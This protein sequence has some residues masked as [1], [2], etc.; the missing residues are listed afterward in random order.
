MKNYE[1][2]CFS[3]NLRF[4]IVG[5]LF[6]NFLS[7]HDFTSTFFTKPNFIDTNYALKK[8]DMM[9]NNILSKKLQCKLWLGNMIL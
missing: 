5:R 7:E 2:F 8:F 9:Y 4:K 6:I 3:I 1:H